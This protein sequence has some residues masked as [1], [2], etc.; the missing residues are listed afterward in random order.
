MLWACR[1]T[2]TFSD[3][4]EVIDRMS[5]KSKLLVVYAHNEE[6]ERPHIHFLID[7]DVSTDTIKNWIK[8]CLNVTTFNKMDWSF[9][10]TYGDD[11]PVDNGY[12]TYMSKGK[13][14]PLYV[15]GFTDS[16]I[17][18]LKTRWVAK[19]PKQRMVQ[20]K[21]KKDKDLTYSDI[22]KIVIGKLQGNSNPELIV[23]TLNEVLIQYDK[24]VGRYKFRDMVDAIVARMDN[25]G[26]VG[27]MVYFCRFTQN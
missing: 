20:S 8:K 15:K 1:V 13:Y 9:K 23:K 4:S 6:C 12:V 14:D 26:W 3:M 10:S 25:V 27:Q 21:L 17:K 2:R 7:T 18:E 19:Q 5:E 22:V 11:V 16:E 24:L